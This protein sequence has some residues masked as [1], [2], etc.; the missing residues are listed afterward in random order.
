MCVRERVR[1]AWGYG[2][3]LKWV[4]TATRRREIENRE[5]ETYTRGFHSMHTAHTRMRNYSWSGGPYSYSTALIMQAL[6]LG[7]SRAVCMVY[8]REVIVEESSQGSPKNRCCGPQE[9]S[10]AN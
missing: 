2:G 3:L 6:V 1:A 9:K 4:V 5:C 10:E 8:V 7:Q